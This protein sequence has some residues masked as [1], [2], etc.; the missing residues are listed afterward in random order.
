MDFG[1]TLKI[2]NMFPKPGAQVK[3]DTLLIYHLVYSSGYKV[4][5]IFK[6]LHKILYLLLALTFQALRGI[7]IFFNVCPGF[8]FV[9]SLCR[10]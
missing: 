8:G 7:L 3:M 6:K 2:A 9:W 10:H 1:Q 5:N 4:H